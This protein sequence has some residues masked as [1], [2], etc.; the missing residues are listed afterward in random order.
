MLSESYLKSKKNVVDVFKGTTIPHEVIGKIWTTSVLLK[1]AREG[2]GV[3]I[4]SSA[5]EIRVSRSS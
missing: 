1:P 3:I 4:G 2:T 5:R